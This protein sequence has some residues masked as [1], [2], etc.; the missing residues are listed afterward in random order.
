MLS[1]N[2][3]SVIA[4]TE[5]WLNSEKVWNQSSSLAFNTHGLKVKTKC[6]HK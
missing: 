2:K 5:T 6:V 1:F 3:T 4:I